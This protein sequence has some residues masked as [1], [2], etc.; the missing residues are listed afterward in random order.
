M[1]IYSRPESSVLWTEFRIDGVRFRLPTGETDRRRAK[2]AETRLREEKRA[3]AAQ[4]RSR[5][6]EWQGKE[7]PTLGYCVARY[8][9]EEG[10]FH[11]VPATTWRAL[12]W[13]TDHFGEAT[14]ITDLTT[15]KIAQMVAHRRGIRVKR[16]TKTKRLV[17]VPCETV[18]NATVNR[19][20]TEPL[21]K[22]FRRARDVWGYPVPYPRWGDLLLPEAAER[23]R[24][25]SADEEAQII[26]ALGSDYGRVFRFMLAAGPRAQGALLTW[27]QIDKLNRI[28]R[29]RNKGMRGQERFYTIPL[30]AAAMAILAECEGHHPLHVFTYEARRSVQGKGVPAD[31]QRVKGK[32]Y[33]IT[34]AGFKSEWRRL[35][36]DAGIAPGFRRHDTRHTTG[37]RFLRATGNLKAASKLLGHSRVET[38]T[39]Y[40]HVLVDDIRS[41][42]EEMERANHPRFLT[43]DGMQKKEA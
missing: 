32:R 43:Q 40:A 27:P 8:W 35:V 34:D 31:R 6:S 20:A 18:S 16:D 28:A 21:R 26:A 4:A 19:Y 36:K 15:N 2:A 7:P 14:L 38:T 30:T 25:A 3:E 41:G 12:E 22:V 23:V 39:R 24:E 11:A 10:R 37:T 29:I 33:P 1:S 13:L 42:L 9:D 17:E 5:R